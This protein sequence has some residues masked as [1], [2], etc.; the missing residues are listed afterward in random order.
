MASRSPS[1]D[2]EWARQRLFG[3]IEATL[4]ALASLRPMALL[5]EDL[6]WADSAT[7]D[8]VEHLL[9]RRVAVPDVGTWRLDD[10]ATP[11]LALQWRSRVQRRPS[12]TTLE[13]HLTEALRPYWQNP[14]KLQRLV[15]YPWWCRAVTGLTN[16][17]PPL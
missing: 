9:A 10:P 15:G 16:T 8:L 2:D 14:T 3:A 11:D 13:L 1:S 5:L 7:L 12:C 17:A 4:A 6:H